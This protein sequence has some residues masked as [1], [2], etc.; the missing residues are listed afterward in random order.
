MTQSTETKEEITIHDAEP[1]SDTKL[2]KKSSGPSL[3][4]KL[5]KE[6]ILSIE[7]EPPHG[8]A[9]API[10]DLLHKLE[11]F[12]VDAVNIPENPLARARISS[13]ALARLIR[14]QTGLPSI[15]H[16]QQ[17][18]RDSA[19]DQRHKAHVQDCALPWP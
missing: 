12:G 10:I 6:P 16:D 9:V 13:I 8:L 17:S 14:E 15:A 19:R 7:L 2:V 11:P 5:G 3:E 18:R 4:E 1:S